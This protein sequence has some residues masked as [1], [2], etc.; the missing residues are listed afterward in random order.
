MFQKWV[1][2]TGSQDE[3]CHGHRSDKAQQKY[4]PGGMT[5]EARLPTLLGRQGQDVFHLPGLE[6]PPVSHPWSLHRGSGGKNMP[7][8]SNWTNGDGSTSWMGAGLPAHWTLRKQYGQYQG[9]G[10]GQPPGPPSTVRLPHT[11]G[12]TPDK[13]ITPTESEL[14]GSERGES[15]PEEGEVQQEE[16]DDPGSFTKMR[17]RD[18]DTES[19]DTTPRR[20][21]WRSA[22]WQEDVL[23]T[24]PRTRGLGKRRMDLGGGAAKRARMESSSSD[25]RDEL[26]ESRSVGTQEVASRLPDP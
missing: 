21:S 13:D 23:L 1:E 11:K 10:E 15:G 20:E 17:F 4:P 18:T 5:P 19:E 26:E 3:R 2:S 12:T 22:R 6:E 24:T 14:A 7:R 8:G 9:P 25:R 16:S